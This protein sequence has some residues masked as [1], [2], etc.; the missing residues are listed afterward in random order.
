[1]V[2]CHPLFSLEANAATKA[3]LSKLAQLSLGGW[4]GHEPVVLDSL[5]V[6]LWVGGQEFY[7]DVSDVIFNHS[8]FMF[9]WKCKTVHCSPKKWELSEVDWD[10]D[11]HIFDS[12]NGWGCPGVLVDLVDV[13]AI[14]R[15][16]SGATEACGEVGGG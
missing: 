10:F 6:G 5:E 7:S 15:L 14:C 13:G 8:W 2:F 4:D 11:T 1:M 3:S 16:C 9:L 12:F